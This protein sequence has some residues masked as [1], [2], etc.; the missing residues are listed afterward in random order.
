MKKER[1]IKNKEVQER[2]KKFKK[3]LELKFNN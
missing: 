3:Q 1:A 2:S